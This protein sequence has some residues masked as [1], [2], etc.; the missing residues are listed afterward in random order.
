MYER[1]E[2]LC[3]TRRTNITAMCKE[4]NISRA[5]LSELKSG[6]TK[7]LSAEKLLK[8]ADY[9]GVSIAYLTGSAARQSST[10]H[11]EQEAANAVFLDDRKIY[12]LPLFENVSAGFGAQ[13]NDCAV[14][15]IPG[16]LGS[17]CEAQETL[18]IRVKGDSMYP[19]IEDGDMIQVHRQNSVDSG[20]IAVILL[21]GEEG[22]VKKILY[23]ENW[24]EL[25]SLN[26]DYPVRRFENADMLRLQVV[27]LVKKVI[28]DI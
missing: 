27:G 10:S 1:I 14:D 6:R 19:K 2:E 26:P 3:R 9:F 8:I 13:A 18:F 7:S 24:I 21:D 16:R 5:S 11:S 4:L 23:G 12:M 22:L 15:Y 28:K 17:S 25:H 20:S